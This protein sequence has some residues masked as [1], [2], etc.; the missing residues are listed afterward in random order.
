VIAAIT[1]RLLSRLWMM[2]LLPG[3]FV[4]FIAY[5]FVAMIGPLGGFAPIQWVLQT[6]P[7]LGQVLGSQAIDIAS[8]AGM[9]S[10]AHVH[11][12]VGIA[13]LIWP[14]TLASAAL[15]G[16]VESGEADLLMSRGVPRR[17]PFLAA[18]AA[19]ILGCCVIA[20]AQWLG[21]LLGFLLNET[22]EAAPVAR[23]LGA[24][25]INALLAAAMGCVALLV[26]ALA[27]E[28]GQVLVIAVALWLL[29]YFNGT[30]APIFDSLAWLQPW[31]LH[32]HCHPQILVATGQIPWTDLALLAAVGIGTAAAGS[33]AWSRRD[34]RA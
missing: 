1:T 32:G 34:I 26:S 12:A 14:L 4:L 24:A 30:V 21:T 8:D 10:I 6:L 11:P 3:A 9:A 19:L 28:R 15:A 20:T 13:L 22:E 29:S 27:S 17:A 31:S 2:T 5:L 25:M 18:L 23:F 7:R 16:L 33:M